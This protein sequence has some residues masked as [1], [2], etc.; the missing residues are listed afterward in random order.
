MANA[1]SGPTRPSIL[2]LRAGLLLLVSSVLLCGAGGNFVARQ[3]GLG[4]GWAI[5]LAVL[6]WIGVGMLLA[7]LDQRIY[8]GAAVAIT[9]LL[10]YLV[11]DFS[12]S[13]LGWS[14][15]LS[16]FLAVVATALL[17]FAFHDFRRIKDELRRWAYR[18]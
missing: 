2:R 15:N 8:Y 1:P 11:Y 5:L 17:G 4:I 13:A 10:A 6:I 18:R 7:R 3:F 16:L 14:A 12:T 9:V